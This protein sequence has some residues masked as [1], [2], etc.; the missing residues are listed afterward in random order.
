MDTVQAI[1]KN[2]KITGGTPVLVHNIDMLKELS[3][4]VASSDD[5]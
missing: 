3:L 4:V 1:F 2:V 5:E